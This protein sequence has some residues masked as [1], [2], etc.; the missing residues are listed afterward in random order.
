MKTQIGT[1]KDT[2]LYKTF[3]DYVV[4]K[5]K[6]MANFSMIQ[7]GD[8]RKFSRMANKLDTQRSRDYIK[9]LHKLAKQLKYD[10]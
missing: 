1:V 6:S 10:K 3:Y 7:N 2:A 4:G 5:F 8:R 9:K